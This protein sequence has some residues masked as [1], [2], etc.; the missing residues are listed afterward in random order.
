MQNFS[1]FYVSLGFMDFMYL[2]QRP[3][4]CSVPPGRQ[5]TQGPAV[6]RGLGR[7]RMRTLDWYISVRGAIIEPPRINILFLNM[8]KVIRPTLLISKPR[9][10]MK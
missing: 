3:A 2:C 4:H 9:G 10:Y 1:P 5:P 6:C 8:A 7:C